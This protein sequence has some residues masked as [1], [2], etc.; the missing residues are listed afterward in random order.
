[1]NQNNN[2]YINKYLKYKNKYLHVKNQIG[3]VTTDT[4]IIYAGKTAKIFNDINKVRTDNGEKTANEYVYDDNM[5]YIT[6]IKNLNSGGKNYIY[7]KF[8][9][10]NDNY[11][12]FLNNS[13]GY[14]IKYTNDNNLSQ[15]SMGYELVF[16]IGDKNKN[17]QLQDA[18]NTYAKSNFG[19]KSLI[20]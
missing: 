20:Y 17:N 12:N 9:I 15:S 14:I 10:N 7:C 5:L 19:W 2:N 3:G 16:F 18:I 13:F 4:N 6:N 11:N 1:M 8:I